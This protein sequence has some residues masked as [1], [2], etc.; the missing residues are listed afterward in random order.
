MSDFPSDERIVTLD[1]LLELVGEARLHGQK[2]V[3]TNGCFDLLHVGHLS[4]LHS[5]RLQGDILVVGVNS[6]RSVRALNKGPNRPLVS[7][8]ERAQMLAALRFVDYVVIFDED[9]PLPLLQRL[10]PDVH[11]KGGDYDVRQLPETPVVESYGGRV[12]IAAIRPGRSTT[13]LEQLL[14]G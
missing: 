4:T 2:L 13:R 14:R 12:H 11:V 1:S 6:D 10:R 7:Q 9:T 8:R 3:F 5:A